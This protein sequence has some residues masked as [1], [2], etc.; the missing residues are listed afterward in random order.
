M[1]PAKVAISNPCDKDIL[2]NAGK[3][4]AATPIVIIGRADPNIAKTMPQKERVKEALS[5]EKSRCI[6]QK[7]GTGIKKA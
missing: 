2:A 4:K 3:A 7:P 5:F 6:A 1:S